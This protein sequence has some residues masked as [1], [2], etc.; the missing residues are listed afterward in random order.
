MK[1]YFNSYY[2]DAIVERVLM[3][4]HRFVDKMCTTRELSEWSGYSTWIIYYDLVERLP[5]IDPDL[6]DEA[7]I[8]LDL[9][10]E[11]S[12]HRAVMAASEKRRSRVA[13]KKKTV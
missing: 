5:K 9:N 1:N 2:E 12:Q 6:G 7:R 8:L 11:E 13:V 10:R 3:H 4:G